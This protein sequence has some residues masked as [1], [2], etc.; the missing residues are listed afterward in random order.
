[1]T[2]SK[3]IKVKKWRVAVYLDH[4]VTSRDYVVF[5]T[6]GQDARVLA[7]ALDGGFPASMTEMDESHAELVKT[8]TEIVAST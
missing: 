2:T 3:T 8:Y 1:M 4:A 6:S 5:A 7:F